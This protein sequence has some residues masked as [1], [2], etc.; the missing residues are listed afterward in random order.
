MKRREVCRADRRCTSWKNKLKNHSMTLMTAH[1]SIRIMQMEVNAE[2]RQSELGM[3]AGLLSRSCRP[4]QK[5]NAGTRSSEM[6]RRT[7]L[8][9]SWMFERLA[10]MDL[11]RQILMRENRLNVRGNL[12]KYIR[13]QA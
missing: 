6:V 4:T 13:Q 5:M 2:F 3:R 11:Y 10:V 9:T 7:M 12:R 8:E 1:E